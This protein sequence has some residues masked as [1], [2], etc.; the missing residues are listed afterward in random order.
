[1][2]KYEGPELE[3]IPVAGK[4][5]KSTLCPTVNSCPGECPAHVNTGKDAPG[6][7]GSNEQCY[8]DCPGFL[9]KDESN[10]QC[11]GDCPGFLY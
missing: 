5:K 1:M 8:G 7:D 10:E 11:T 4:E 6:K 2:E 9:W 3:V